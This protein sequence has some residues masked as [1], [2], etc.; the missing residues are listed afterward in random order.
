MPVIFG[1]EIDKKKGLLLLG[2][3]VAGVAVVV[4]VRSRGASGVS[5]G[6]APQAP[7][8]PYYGEM[9]GGGGYTVQAP[10]DQAAANYNA[11]LQDVQ[12]QAARFGLEQ[13]RA[14]QAERERQWSLA[15]T[16]TTAYNQMQMALFGQETQ[17]GASRSEY[18]SAVYGR[19]AAVQKVVTGYVQQGRIKPE[20]GKGESS[21]LDPNTGEWRCKTSGRSGVQVAGDVIGSDLLSAA[22]AW[23]RQYTQPPESPASRSTPPIGPSGVGYA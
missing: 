19:E 11:Q 8:E 1:Q 9:G 10:S 5:A 14:E 15:D 22:R 12:L 18:E 3:I 21:Y 4:Y 23:I 7:S 16:L 13:Q 17:V 2:V 6:A 20:C